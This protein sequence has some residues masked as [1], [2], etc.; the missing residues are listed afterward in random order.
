MTEPSA[1]IIK[2][3]ITREG[4]RLTTFE[5]IFHR[6]VLA[7]ANTHRDFSRNSA[8]SRA[9][10]VEKQLEKV[11]QDPAWPLVWP[12]EQ[13]GMQG[14]TDLTN[15]D[16]WDAEDL[17]QNVRNATSLLVKH[18]LEDHPDKST[19]LH[20]SLIN[21]LLE[22][23]M[24]HTA[25]ISA[26]EYQNFFNQR[27]SPLAQPEIRVLA[28]AMECEYNLST[29]KLLLP[30]EWHLPYVDDDE[31][32]FDIESLKSASVA[33]CAR[34]STLSHEGIRDILKDMGLYTKLHYADPAHASPFEHVATPCTHHFKYSE[35]R[36]N[37]MG[38][39]QLR[40]IELGF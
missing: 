35:H 34:V 38:W 7:E 10:P 17:F 22:P 25:I 20:K 24:W 9:I 15:R 37:F 18:Y 39:D 12:S 8:S 36:G 19:R 28:E 26:T 14:G 6:F 21:R 11:M 27:C 23:F 3:S 5:C 16:L 13:P 40:H 2:D 31:L 1:K 32:H 4:H 33:R 29:P 30:G